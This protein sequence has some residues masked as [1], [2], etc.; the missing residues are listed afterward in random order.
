MSPQVAT[1]PPEISLTTSAYLILIF[2]SQKL[3]TIQLTPQQAFQAFDYFFLQQMIYDVQITEINTRPG[4]FY[5]VKT[6]Q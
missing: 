6:M 3:P 5:I 1:T 4:I 2:L